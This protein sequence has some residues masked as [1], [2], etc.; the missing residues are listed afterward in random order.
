MAVRS[1]NKKTIATGLGTVLPRN[2]ALGPRNTGILWDLL[3]PDVVTSAFVIHADTGLHVA[4]V[5]SRDADCSVRAFA[6]FEAAVDCRLAVAEVVEMN[7]D[8]MVMVSAR[9][10]SER[11]AV[12][13]VFGR[14]SRIADARLGIATLWNHSPISLCA[15]LG[16]GK[17]RLMHI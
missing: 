13:R 6:A 7:T 4:G 1:G 8:A 2:R 5:L 14:T 9:L 12:L 10:E 3:G 17:F 11:D 16:L 15:L